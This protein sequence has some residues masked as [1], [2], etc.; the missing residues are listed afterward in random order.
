[1]FAVAPAQRD[2]SAAKAVAEQADGPSESVAAKPTA[3]SGTADGGDERPASAWAATV[4]VLPGGE[5]SAPRPVTSRP[6]GEEAKVQLVRDLQTEL[7]RVGC[8]EGDIDGSWGPGS[9]RAMSAFTD[10][11]NA[12]LPVDE[13][14]FILLTLLQ[15]HRVTA[16][17]KSCPRGQVLSG[18]RCLPSSVVARAERRRG[19]TTAAARNEQHASGESIPATASKVSPAAVEPADRDRSTESQLTAAAARARP[20]DLQEGR[21]SIG[22]PPVPVR[23]PHTITTP[24]KAEPAKEQAR[25]A[26]P[27]QQRLAVARTEMPESDVTS[28]SSSGRDKPAAEAQRTGRIASPDRSDAGVPLRNEGHGSEAGRHE[29]VSGADKRVHRER[30]TKFMARP[31][32]EPAPRRAAEPRVVRHAPAP[33]Y[34]PRPS[35][36]AFKSRSQRMVFDL[37]QRPDRVY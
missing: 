7:K 30:P 3:G 8:Y 35:R 24:G 32:H 16:C 9:K 28:P 23:A 14:D 19:P 27:S 31:R 29:G 33:R 21:M 1:M 18:E 15:G 37:F 6:R 13:P 20:I 5:T 10:R 2:E 36:P 17:G 4:Q 12:T 25:K 26:R 22:G 11:V 34:V